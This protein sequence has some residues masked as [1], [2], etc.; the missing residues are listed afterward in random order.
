MDR[1]LSNMY[2]RKNKNKQELVLIYFPQ[3]SSILDPGPGFI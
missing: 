2:E 3:I 1:K